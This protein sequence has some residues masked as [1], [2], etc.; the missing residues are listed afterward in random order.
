MLCVPVVVV[1]CFCVCFFFLFLFK[2]EHNPLHGMPLLIEISSCVMHVTGTFNTKW[3]IQ[4]PN[5][6]I[7]CAR[8]RSFVRWWCACECAVGRVWELEL[9]DETRQSR[10]K[11]HDMHLPLRCGLHDTNHLE[12]TFLLAQ[13]HYGSLLILF[14]ATQSHDDFSCGHDDFHDFATISRFPRFRSGF[15]F[16]N[17][18]H[19]TFSF[20][21]KHS[22]NSSNW[23]IQ[24]T[25]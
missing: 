21:T 5:T 12:R 22:L 9:G 10:T 14:M 6:S 18:F 13:A 20:Q 25:N 3:L 16:T 15:F 1:C 24:R 19:F 7:Q 8:H 4:T 2:N 11:N 17:K 23:T